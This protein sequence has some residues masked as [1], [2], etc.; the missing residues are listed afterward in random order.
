VIP[1]LFQFLIRLGIAKVIELNLTLLA[2][3]VMHPR[4]Y[5]GSSHLPL[6]EP[7]SSLLNFEASRFFS[8]SLSGIR[9]ERSWKKNHKM[10]LE[11]NH[12]TLL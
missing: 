3:P 12:K 6:P 11:F 8:E 2:E 5:H 10:Y 1:A 4:V 9:I 7:L